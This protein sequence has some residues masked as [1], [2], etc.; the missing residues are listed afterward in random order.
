MLRV[1]LLLIFIR[2]ELFSIE[3][4]VIGDKNFPENNLTRQEVRAIFLDKKRFINEKKILVMN[5]K[6]SHPLR[7]CFEK[8]I[9]KKT[10]RSLERYWRKAYYQGK[11]P[12]KIVSSEEMLF[13]YLDGV[14]PSIG[15]SDINATIGRE[16]TVLYR[17]E[18]L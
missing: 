10:K 5:H 16:V 18:C 17:V 4:V 12:P 8:N 2:L 14:S 3:L 1:L 11:R 7:Q 9:L 13:L 6:V 15:Y